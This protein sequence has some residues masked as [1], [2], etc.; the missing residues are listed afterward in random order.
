MIG[1]QEAWRELRLLLAPRDERKLLGMRRD[2]PMP[3]LMMTYVILCKSR[4]GTRFDGARFDGAKYFC[5]IPDLIGNFYFYPFL[6]K[7]FVLL[8]WT[9]LSPFAC[10]LLSIFF[11]T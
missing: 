5:E 3:P 9:F 2:E 10:P 1:I 11:Y 7:G 8:L 6:G 4:H